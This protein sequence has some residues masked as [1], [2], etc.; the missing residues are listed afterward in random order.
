M[1]GKKI[2]CPECFQPGFVHFS[3]YQAEF[4]RIVY[5]LDP[6]EP[7]FLSAPKCITT[8]AKLPAHVRLGDGHKTV[9][10]EPSKPNPRKRPLKCQSQLMPSTT[11][12]APTSQ[13]ETRPSD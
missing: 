5:H 6:E 8:D 4:Y 1:I 10:P 2:V 7:H 9:R 13:A 3:K 11:F 12:S